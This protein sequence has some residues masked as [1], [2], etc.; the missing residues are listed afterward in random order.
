MAGLDTYTKLLL[1]LNGA[2]GAQATTDASGSGHAITFNNTAE[3]DTAQKK[4][5]NASL[6]L[7]GDSDYLSVADH[8][9]WNYGT[10][11]YTVDFQLRFAAHTALSGLVAQYDDADNRW[12]LQW[13]TD[14]KFYLF[15]RGSAVTI[16]S[17][18]TFA[19]TPSDNI[20]YHVELV[21]KNSGTA[22]YLCFVNGTAVAAQTNDSSTMPDIA[23]SLYIGHSPA[24][25]SYLEGW[26][27]EVRIS[28][29]IARHTANFTAPTREYGRISN[30][31]FLE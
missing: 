7:D 19:F 1:H 17:N 27:D 8:A 22:G 4:F 28:K 13:N 31:I 23:G 30:P 10:G 9:D 11:E 29:G 2:D 16:I 21:K 3:L 20:W 25:P 5:G 24:D 26:V 6:L 18:Y 12:Q 14:N 15:V